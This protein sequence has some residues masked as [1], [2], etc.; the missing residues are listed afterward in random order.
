ME[1][2]Q[3][4]TGTD[5]TVTEGIRTKVTWLLNAKKVSEASAENGYRVV[6][7]AGAGPSGTQKGPRL[8]GEV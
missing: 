4:S 5:S 1:S 6:G 3:E 8:Q 2:L 7:Q